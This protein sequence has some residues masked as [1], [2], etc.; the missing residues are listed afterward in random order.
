[1]DRKQKRKKKLIVHAV[2]TIWVI[3]LAVI[4][5]IITTHAR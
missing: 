5:V 1:M 4:M 3:T 2:W